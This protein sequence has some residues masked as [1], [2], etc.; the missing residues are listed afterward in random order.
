MFF[1]AITLF[2]MIKNIF[3]F[4]HGDEARNKTSSG[5]NRVIYIWRDNM[6]NNFERMCIIYEVIDVMVLFFIYAIMCIMLQMKVYS[7]HFISMFVDGTL[8]DSM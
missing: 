4:N 7:L 8:R 5:A 3:S 2:G 6:R 1:I